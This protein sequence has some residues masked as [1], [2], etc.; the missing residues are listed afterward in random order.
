MAQRLEELEAENGALRRETRKLRQGIPVDPTPDYAANS[1]RDRP[2][3]QQTPRSSYGDPHHSQQQQQQQQREF[4][5]PPSTPTGPRRLLLKSPSS[6][7]PPSERPV[8]TANG[9]PSMR[10]STAVLQ[11]M[12]AQRPILTPSSHGNGAGREQL[13]SSSGLL[14]NA[15]GG[16]RFPPPFL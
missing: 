13:R 7:S 10:P 6:R 3:S 16:R 1:S 11:N 12:S 15:L 14:P 2:S 8:G 9:Q 4:V 5:A